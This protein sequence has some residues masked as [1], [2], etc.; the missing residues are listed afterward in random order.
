M[1]QLVATLAAALMAGLLCW[2]L[3]RTRARFR[4]G[5]WE[6]PRVAAPVGSLF[7][8]FEAGT[9]SGETGGSLLLYQTAVPRGLF[10]AGLL[11]EN[12]A[13]GLG[14]CGEEVAAAIELNLLGFALRAPRA[15]QKPS[16][17]EVPVHV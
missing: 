14:R 15:H 1:P 11:D 8:S 2:R 9:G 7:P 10:A 4:A 3:F 6:E 13:N 5:R 16:R 17:R 12:A